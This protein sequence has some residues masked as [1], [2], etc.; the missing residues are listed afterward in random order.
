MEPAEPTVNAPVEE[1]QSHPADSL[2]EPENVEIPE[3][4]DEQPAEVVEEND[5]HEVEKKKTKRDI[6]EE[7]K[8][9]TRKA[10][11][12]VFLFLGIGAI[13]FA[14]ALFPMS[15]PGF[16]QD[17]NLISDPDD[18][19][20]QINHQILVYGAPPFKV[21]VTVE[22]WVMDNFGGD[23]EV[24]LLPG[25]CQADDLLFETTKMK[26]D[27]SP[28]Y[29][30]IENAAPGSEH[31]VKLSVDPTGGH[32][33]VAWYS[34]SA[35]DPALEASVHVYS[36]RILAGVPA[37]GSLFLSGFAF[38]GAQKHGLKMK[39]LMTP[40]GK[41]SP[42]EEALDAAKF[43]R[44]SSG[45][46]TEP[47]SMSGPAGPPEVDSTGS[48]SPPVAEEVPSDAAP[49]PEE[50]TPNYV[51]TG[52]GYFYIQNEDGSYQPQAYY[53]GPDGRYWPYQG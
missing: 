53:Q 32:C 33:F 28:G 40:P 50:K 18:S 3:T 1:E 22:V 6:L 51:P 23:V 9:D 30:F 46:G 44:L 16:W 35:S 8:E 42:E 52:D 13:L 12:N 21:D 2:G 24:Y 47:S 43:D 25:S 38:W 26:N 29:G 34:N 19:A 41:K 5:E 7:L 49:E 37:V 36:N 39:E 48:T 31:K 10:R 15:N 17:S 45:P 14:F 27:D 4:L 20:G 11:W